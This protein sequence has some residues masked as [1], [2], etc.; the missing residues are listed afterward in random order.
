MEKYNNANRNSCVLQ[1]LVC[2]L[3]RLSA[4][5]F[6]REALDPPLMAE[7]NNGKYASAKKTL[8]KAINNYID[9]DLFVA[10]VPNVQALAKRYL[11]ASSDLK[12]DTVLLKLIFVDFS[13]DF[14]SFST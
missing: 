13:F 5:M 4:C 10:I 1:R 2:I 7:K 9:I 6:D 12:A 14:H 3:H 11:I 8:Q